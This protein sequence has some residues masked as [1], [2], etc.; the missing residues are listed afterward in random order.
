M[1]GGRSRLSTIFAEMLDRGGHG[2][3]GDDLGPFAQRLDLDLESR[4]RRHDDLVPLRPVVL[5]SAVPASGGQPQPVDQH[6]RQGIGRRLAHCGGVRALSEGPG[7][8]GD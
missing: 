3:L 6:D 7:D 2:R 1:I 8:C 5:H 4:V